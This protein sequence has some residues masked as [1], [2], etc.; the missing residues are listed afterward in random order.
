MARAPWRLAAEQQLDA[1]KLTQS[2]YTAWRT[3]QHLA[4]AAAAAV[5][6]CLASCCNSYSQCVDLH[7]CFALSTNIRSEFGLCN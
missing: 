2:A 6:C 1:A 3:T 5:A 7:R 4:T